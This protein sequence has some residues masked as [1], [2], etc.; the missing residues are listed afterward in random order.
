[1]AEKEDKKGLETWACKLLP[2]TKEELT[3]LKDKE[4][5]QSYQQMI[6]TLLERYLNP[7]KADESNSK[8]IKELKDKNSDLTLSYDKL[9]SDY[10]ELETQSGLSQSGIESAN[11]A[12]AELEEKLQHALSMIPGENTMVVPVNPYQKKVLEVLSER[13]SKKR[14]R[15]DITPKTLSM[16]VID[17][18]I[19]KCNAFTIDPLSGEEKRRIK[20]ELEAENNG[21]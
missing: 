7:K 15:D 4:G 6:E 9:L 3:E 11:E 21:R 20:L 2:E 13:E 14:K 17:E 1:M 12:I 18:V 10:R 8:L 5:F 16:F 19:V